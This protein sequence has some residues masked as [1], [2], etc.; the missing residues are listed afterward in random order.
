VEGGPVKEKWQ[1]RA[2]AKHD[3]T[4]NGPDSE[5]YLVA[6]AEVFLRREI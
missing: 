4:H 6:G 5:K 1:R 3:A 2:I